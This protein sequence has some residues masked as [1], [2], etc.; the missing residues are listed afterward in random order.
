LLTAGLGSDKA[1]YVGGT[2]SLPEKTE[3]KLALSDPAAAK[4]TYKGGESGIPYERISSLEYGQKAGRRIGV[5]V[6]VS[7]LALF[8]KKRKHYLTIGFTDADGKQQGAV[9]ELGKDTVRSTLV[10]L[11]ARS[12]KQVEYESDEAKKHVG[13]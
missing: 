4:F 11:E 3:G 12:G 9:F 5:A 1:A 7:P 6:M 2:L 13:N 10:T 8:S